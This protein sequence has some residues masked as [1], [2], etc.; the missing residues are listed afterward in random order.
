MNDLGLHLANYFFYVFHTLL[1]LVNLFGWIFPKTRKLNLIT[2]LITFGSW[3]ILGL[4]KG[5][6]Y[7][8]LTDWHYAILRRLGETQL[9]SSYIAFLVEKLTGWLPETNL[10]NN[11][12]VGLALVA[13]LCSLWVNLKQK[14]SSPEE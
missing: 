2:L 11:L 4:W 6:G 10:V 9:P 14:K 5:W 13:L 1:I 3:G 8:F 12:T 7:C